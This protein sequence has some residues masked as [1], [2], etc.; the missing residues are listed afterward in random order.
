LKLK[1]IVMEMDAKV[2]GDPVVVH[3]AE[4][5]PRVILAERWKALGMAAAWTLGVSV[6]VAMFVAYVLEALVPRRVVDGV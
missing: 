5:S 4:H 6:L 1:M 2:M 3:M